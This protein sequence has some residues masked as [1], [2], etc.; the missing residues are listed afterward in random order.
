M[1]ENIQLLTMGFTVSVSFI[2]VLAGV[3]LNNSRLTDLRVDFHKRFDDQNK[4]FDDQN[5]RIDAFGDSRRAEM[6]AVQSQLQGE[7]KASRSEMHAEMAE[8]RILRERQHS[9]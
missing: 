3:L 8:I 6:K 7:I 5:K 2:A 1:Q 4:R 9:E